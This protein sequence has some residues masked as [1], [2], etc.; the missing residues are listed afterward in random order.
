MV[1][2]V[3]K[4]LSMSMGDELVLDFDIMYNDNLG[5]RHQD[6]LNNYA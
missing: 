4:D 5:T 2:V 3:L 6:Y 1:V